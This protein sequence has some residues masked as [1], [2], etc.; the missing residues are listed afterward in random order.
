MWKPQNNEV[1]YFRSTVSPVIV[2][3][4]VSH[5]ETNASNLSVFPYEYILSRYV[6]CSLV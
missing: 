6:M 3:L 4:H 2:T 1:V 5:K